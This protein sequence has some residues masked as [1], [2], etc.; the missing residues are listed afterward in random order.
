MNVVVEDVIIRVAE[1]NIKEFDVVP[2]FYDANKAAPEQISKQA[3]YHGLKRAHEYSNIGEISNMLTRLWNRDKPDR[4][5]AALL[6]YKN[7]LIID[8]AKTGYINDYTNYPEIEKQINKATGGPNGRMP[9]FFQF[10]KNGRRD[11]TTHKKKKRKWAKQNNSTMNRI[12][13]AFDDIGNINMNWAGVPPFNWQML[14]SEPCLYNR[15]DIVSEFCDLD[16]IK[17]S[18]AIADAEESPAEK[19][20]L[21]NNSIID[22]HIVYTMTEKFGSLEVCYP[23]IVKH[24]FAGE[25]VMKPAH[26]QTF[27]RIFGDIAVKNLR[28]NLQNYKTC[29]DCGAKIPAWAESHACPKNLQGFYDCIDCG[30]K[31]QRTNSRQ[32]RCQE[33]QEHHRHDLRHVDKVKALQ[34]KRE[35]AQLF[36]SFL[37]SHWKKT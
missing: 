16:S 1:R 7:N 25:A 12:C 26:K 23:Y 10:S 14:L 19:G 17:V 27:W 11:K 35:R 8:A 37:Q 32:V 3:Q 34:E 5:A 18:L 22:E 6:C 36:T 4:I 33:C 31:C 29:P 28:K 15:M 20:I 13:K 2:L 30:K 9:F 24:L 21:D